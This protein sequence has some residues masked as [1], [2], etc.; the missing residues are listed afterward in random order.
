MATGGTALEDDS[1]I[2]D[3]FEC[4][5]CFESLLEKE[6]RL[7]HCWHTFC[8]PRLRQL[9]LEKGMWLDLNKFNFL[10]LKTVRYAVDEHMQNDFVFPKV[11]NVG[12]HTKKSI[13]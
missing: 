4:A 8:T 3:L 5:I 7:L 2:C 1:N 12:V 10:P 11:H 6:P 9:E 13:P